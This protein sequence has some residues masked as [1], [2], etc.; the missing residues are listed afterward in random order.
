MNTISHTLNGPL[1]LSGNQIN[2]IS[3]G[4]NVPAEV[5]IAGLT[6]ISPLLGAVALISYIANRRDC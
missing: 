5:V 3:G 1:V 4:D 2:E 6:V